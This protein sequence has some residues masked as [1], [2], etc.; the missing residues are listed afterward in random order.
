MVTFAGQ[1]L[2]WSVFVLLQFLYMALL[3]PTLPGTLLDLPFI[4][5]L[6]LATLLLDF[7]DLF[8][9]LAS[10][11]ESL[12]AWLSWSGF[13][14]KQKKMITPTKNDMI[15]PMPTVTMTIAA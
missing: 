2:W 7:F 3:L 14:K 1:L 10:F 11:L 9:L 12:L 5:F 4:D 15:A 6:L 8:A 13:L